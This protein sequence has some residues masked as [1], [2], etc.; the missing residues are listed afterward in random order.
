FL[1]ADRGRV[2]PVPRRAAA[3]RGS[4]PVLP[5]P[6]HRRG[7]LLRA[8]VDLPLRAAAAR[9][10]HQPAGRGDRGLHR[11]PGRRPAGGHALPLVGVPEVGLPPPATAVPRPHRGAA[12]AAAGAALSAHGELTAGSIR[13]ATAG[14]ARH[15]AG[16]AAGISRTAPGAPCPTPV[17]RRRLPPGPGP[18]PTRDRKS[19]RLN[20]SHVKISYAVFCLKK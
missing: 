3:P 19:T 17:G 13:S 6:R 7:A 11:R 14:P 16:P 5:D 15:R 10:P 9:A 18:A 8:A 2:V 4:D 1:R 20:S 12:P